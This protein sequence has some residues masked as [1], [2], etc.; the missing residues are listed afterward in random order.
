MK[1]GWIQTKD[2]TT[3]ENFA[4]RTL[5][6]LVYMDENQSQTVKQAVESMGTGS[7]PIFDTVTANRVIGAVY[8]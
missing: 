8:Q 4:P 7:N 1:Q 5:A 6:Q 3:N 2:G